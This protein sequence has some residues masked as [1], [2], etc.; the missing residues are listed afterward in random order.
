MKR[1]SL[2][3]AHFAPSTPSFSQSQYID[4]IHASGHCHAPSCISM[5]LINADT[6]ESSCL[7]TPIYGNGGDEV[8]NEDGYIVALPPCIWSN[9]PNDQQTHGLKTSP[10]FVFGYQFDCH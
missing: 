7:V 1:E 10:D 6:G 3:F 5:E 8:M 2:H 4:L 9:D